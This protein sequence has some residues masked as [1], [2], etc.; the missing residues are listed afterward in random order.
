MVFAGVWLETNLG[1][2]VLS[3]GRDSFARKDSCTLEASGRH[4]FYIIILNGGWANLGVQ[5][6]D[7]GDQP[8][9][10][11]S[12]FSRCEGWPDLLPS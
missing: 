7:R 4:L 1:M 10:L 9:L 2:E 8:Q 3:I 6:T 11:L 5:L 12:E